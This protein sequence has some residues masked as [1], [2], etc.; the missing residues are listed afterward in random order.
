[1]EELL[2][3]IE[4]ELSQLNDV[5]K[6]QEQR[7]RV[8]LLWQKYRGEDR[9]VSMDEVVDADRQNTGQLRVYSSGLEGLDSMIKEF[10][11]SELITIAGPTKNGKTTLAMTLTANML[12]AGH[13][14]CWF[15]YE[16]TPLE[17]EEAMPGDFLP[18]IYTPRKM[19]TNNTK[20][21]EEKIVEAIAK[22]D[23]Q[24]FFIDHLHYVCDLTGKGNENTSIRI[25]ATMQKLKRMAI[26]WGV[27]IFLL[28]H[29]TKIKPTEEPTVAN[30]RDSSLIAAESNTVLYVRRQGEET[31][32]SKKTDLFVIA[33]RRHG[34]RNGGTTLEYDYK[35][36]E[37]KQEY[38]Q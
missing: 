23:A 6:R 26:E 12:R 25:G 38:A 28:A 37:L 34:G 36:R 7:R 15:S 20:W 2:K 13:I 10:R 24:V 29:T 17:F 22:Y 5:K 1:M 4:G 16:M 27:C 31:E 33:V 35:A 9:I 8:E 30:L 21:I 19:Q 14:P 18:R 32:H 3:K 11:D